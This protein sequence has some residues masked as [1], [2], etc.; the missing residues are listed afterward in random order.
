MDNARLYREV[1]QAKENAEAANH[2]KDQ[3]LAVLSHE[4]RT[5][6][7]PVLASLDSLMEEEQLPHRLR[8]TMEVIRRNV[9]L[10]ARLIDDL[11]DL[12]RISRNKVPLNLET[13]DA[14]ACL[15]NALEICRG[16]VRLKKLKLEINL[17]ATDRYVRGDPAR[18]Q[19]VFW[20]LLKNA[21]KFTPPK[22]KITVGTSNPADAGEPR[23]LV[24]EVSDTGIGIPAEVLPRIFDAF[25]QGEISI[26][27]RFGGLGLG[28]AIS[29]ALV[30]MHGGRLE[31]SSAGSGLGATF[32]VR[33]PTISCPILRRPR[34]PRSEI[35]TTRQG[36]RI[37]LVDDHR[38]TATT[39]K[40]LLNRRGYEVRTASTVTAALDAAA[41]HEFDL[42][43]SDIGLPDGSGLDLLR[44]LKNSRPITGIALSGYGMEEDVQKSKTAGF[45]EH[46]TKPVNLQ[47]LEDIIRQLFTHPPLPKQ[48]PQKSPSPTTP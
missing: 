27:R 6:L 35:A 30:E 26:T 45:V 29:K 18:L 16:D 13:V 3:F 37:L 1:Q 39:M 33:L 31:A 11:L 48:K 22:G 20:N 10:E 14:H 40:R 24:I 23:P 41:S 47:H 19:Q 17:R 8:K 42:L 36:V 38:D 46:L 21:V 32:T 34:T 7:T 44:Q 25:E 2:A 28:L 5:P 4:L 12:A 15:K 9:E 43:I